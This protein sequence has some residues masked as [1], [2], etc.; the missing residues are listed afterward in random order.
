MHH[1][2]DRWCVGLRAA[3]FTTVFGGAALTYQHQTD[4]GFRRGVRL[5]TE[6]GPVALHYR[7]VE[8]KHKLRTRSPEE[9]AAEWKQLDD[10]YATS[11]VLLLEELQVLAAGY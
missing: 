9:A 3:A 8:L 2:C 1:V 10:A 5:W 7:W 4:E 11:T 6:A